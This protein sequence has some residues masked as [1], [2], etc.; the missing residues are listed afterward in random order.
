MDLNQF[1]QV[2]WRRRLLVALVTAIVIA[3]AYGVLRLVDPVYQSTATVAVTTRTS[4]P[5]NFFF[6]TTMDSIVPVYADAA[7]AR[8][9]LNQAAARLGRQPAS[10]HVD[11]FKA[12]PIIRIRARSTKPTLAKTS[13]E[14]VARTLLARVR[15]GEVGIK[16]LKLTEVDAAGLPT[17]PVFPNRKLTFI[18]AVLL[19]LGLGV[20]AAV[21]RDNLTTT[22]ESA[23]DLARVAGVP[24]FGEIPQESAVSRMTTVDS[25]QSDPRLRVV[26]EALRDLRTNLMFSERSLHSLAITSPDGSHGKT[27]IAFGLAVTLARA[28]T[29]TLLVDADLRRGRVAEMLDLPR[30]PGLSEVLLGDF[31][32]Q[33]VVHDT[34][35]DSL[36]VMTGGRRPTDPGELL[37]VEFPGVLKELEALYEI[38]VIDTTPA[39]PVTDARVVARYTDATLL[40]VSAGRTRRRQVRT[41][42]E[43]LALIGVRP[44]AVV[45]NNAKDP[46]GSKYYIVEEPKPGEQQPTTRRSRTRGAVRQ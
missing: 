38:V 46:G 15:R 43:R 23:E 3:A 40:I 4:D 19:G 44:N 18:V 33:D 25:L 31:P 20:A 14:S 30:D 13:A 35:L 22:I 37:T 10:I 2:L 41:A 26:S 42:I 24:A 36:H 8:S 9:T 39:A 29:R 11:T 1:L 7:T 45:L 17:S 6:Y 32:P 27:T 12:S 16:A 34:G 5:N 21:L 28:G